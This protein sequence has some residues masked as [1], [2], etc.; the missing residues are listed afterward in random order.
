MGTLAEAYESSAETLDQCIDLFS[1]FTDL[2]TLHVFMLAEK[3]IN[4]SNRAM[5]ELGL[6]PKRYYSRLK[7]LV[8][9]GVLEKVNGIYVYTPTGEILH[10]LGQTL[11]NFV[12]NRQRIGLLLSLS[13]SDA[14]SEEERQKI[15]SMIVRNT[16][17]GKMLGSMINGIPQEKMFKISEYKTL[18]ETLAREIASSKKSVF[19]STRYVDL[20]VVDECLKAF[21]RGIDIKVLSS[22]EGMSKKMNK[23]RMMLSPK[24]FIKIFEISEE[25]NI[26][27]V[28]RETEV[29]FSFCIIDGYKCLFEFPIIGGEFSIAFKLEDEKTSAKF[30]QLFTSIWGS[31]DQKTEKSQR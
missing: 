8:D 23:L 31:C 13:K 18:V 17:V 14:L 12:D 1:V 11:M 6:T 5:K 3:G 20:L 15:N 29:P 28:L 30:T 19:L 26:S 9:V 22:K 16:G 21:G 7:E 24:I 27:D 4:N 10:K 2:D 25:T